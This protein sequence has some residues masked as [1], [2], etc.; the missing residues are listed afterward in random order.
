MR[1]RAL[2]MAILALSILAS[3][4]VLMSQVLPV[5]AYETAMIEGEAYH[6]DYDFAAA[7]QSYSEA[8]RKCIDTLRIPEIEFK[9]SQ[10][11]NGR[12]MAGYCQKPK[13]VA[14]KNFSLK[15]FFLYYPLA[16]RSWRPAPNRLD[17]AGSDFSPVVW[18]PRGSKEAYWS[19]ADTSGVRNIYYTREVGARW[20]APYK[21]PFSS[22]ED[23]IY[24]MVSGG[25]LYFAS[26]GLYGVGG[27][28]IYVCERRSD[29]RWGEPRNLGFPYSSPYDDFLF[30][31]TPDGRYSI[32]ASNRDC[33]VDS[34]SVYVIE[35]EVNPVSS[36][37]TN[38]R[39]LRKLCRLDHPSDLKKVDN[40][41]AMSTSKAS[42]P[43][44]ELYARKAAEVRRLR[45]EISR[46]NRELSTLRSFYHAANTSAEREEF[47][48]KIV[49]KEARL[50]GLQ[51]QLVAA[52]KDLQKT[53][54]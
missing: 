18:F 10:S 44:T 32:F 50:P 52:N 35:R 27:Y 33:S 38:V 25:K 41:S 15:D 26:K 21:M 36:A 51:S 48:N 7:V 13:V 19:M 31:N 2:K 22:A 11:R 8:L 43:N 40:K 47:S 49:K 4:P 14:R 54:M 39:D 3:A 46:V 24:P 16:D 20:S 34:V 5:H 1:I 42:D 30:V 6:A 23:E 9:L 37:V 45:E 53:E 29:G 28:D 12:A 17:P